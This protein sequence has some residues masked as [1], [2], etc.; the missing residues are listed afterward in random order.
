MQA[1]FARPGVV[2]VLLCLSPAPA[3]ADPL[4]VVETIPAAGAVIDT[5]HTTYSVRFDGLVDHRASSLSIT[6]GGRVVEELRPLLNA[7]PE[8]LY[9]SAPELPNG[10][11]ELHWSARSGTDGS[12]VTGAIPFL[13]RRR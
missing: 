13:V 5:R 9:G 3:F 7:A 12:T 10:S 2:L 4:H 1:I 11:Y 6:Q 8:V